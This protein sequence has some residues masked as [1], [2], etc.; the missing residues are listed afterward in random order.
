MGLCAWSGERFL[1]ASPA[2][3][4]PRCAHPPTPMTPPPVP[5]PADPT[6]DVGAPAPAWQCNTK[7]TYQPSLIIRKRRH[8]WLE[9]MSTRN[10][11]RV[12]RRRMLKGRQRLTA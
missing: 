8:G 9:R 3:T 11:R 12:V 7:R 2:R 5:P 4:R 10:G 1:L 6:E